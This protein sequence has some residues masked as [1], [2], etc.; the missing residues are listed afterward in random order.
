M[1]VYL[2]Y[3][4]SAPIEPR[5]LNRMIDVYKNDIGNAD[6][7]TH[8]FGDHARQDVEAARKQVATLLG[9]QP[10]EVFFTSGATES[11]NIAIQGLRKYAEKTNKKHIITTGIEHHAV[12]N[13]VKAMSSEGF[14]VEIINPDTSG[15]VSASEIEKRI[16]PDTLLVSVMHVNNETGII[17]PVKELG[18]FLSEKS[19]LF[20]IDATQSCGKLVKEVKELEYDM[21]SFSA[22]KLMGPQ[23]VGVLV[24]RRKNYQLPPVSAIMYGGQQEKGI[25]P[26][27][28][29]VALVA[30]L[31][32]ACEIAEKEYKK[33]NEKAKKIKDRILD[34][35]NNSGVKY[36]INGDQNYCVNTSINI[37]FLG[38]SSEA[39]MMST[40]QFC[41]ISNGSACTSESYDPSYV[42]SAMGLPV[43]RI[44]SSVRISWGPQSDEEEIVKQ[45]SNLLEVCKNF[46]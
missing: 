16:R 12:L 20:H 24:L 37:C 17:Q 44:E 11:N 9:V 39:L 1:S 28:I 30:G 33:N 3:N 22:H 15:R 25:R 41:S 19:V 40:K 13:T 42:L 46:Q 43:D 27:T 38:V 18:D 10:D 31:G 21:L 23:G 32:K 7:R 45:F 36:L 35:L 4:A 2:D 6:S 5:V 26:G 8:D 34:T 29:P 14:N